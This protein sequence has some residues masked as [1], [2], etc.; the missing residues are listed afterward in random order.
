MAEPVEVFVQA[1]PNPNS[2]KFT[3]NRIIAEKGQSFNSPQ[4][5]ERSPLAQKLYE[6][7]GVRSLFFLKDFIS[8]GRD[9]SYDWEEIVPKIVE[10]I[11]DHFNIGT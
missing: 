3:L 7:P 9:P 2:L 4:E 5:A 11:Q 8:V 1:T 6:V 10:K